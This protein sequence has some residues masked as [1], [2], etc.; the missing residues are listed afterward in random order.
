MERALASDEGFLVIATHG[1][2][3]ERQKSSDE[4]ESKRASQEMLYKIPLLL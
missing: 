3:R 1:R 4:K 2:P